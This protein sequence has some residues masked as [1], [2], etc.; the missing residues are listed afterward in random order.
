M[1]RDSKVRRCCP[2]RTTGS[3]SG[4]SRTPAPVAAWRSAFVI[5]RARQ[6]W[7]TPTPRRSTSSRSACEAT[8]AKAAPVA[9]VSIDDRAARPIEVASATFTDFTLALDLATEGAA[10]THMLEVAF[11]NG[12]AEQPLPA[13]HRPRQGLVPRGRSAA[14][15]DPGCAR[16]AGRSSGKRRRRP[17]AE[18]GLC[19]RARQ[20]QA[21]SPHR[22][23]RQTRGPPREG[24]GGRDRRAS[25]AAT[26]RTAGQAASPAPARSAAAC[27]RE[28][29]ARSLLNASPEGKP[30]AP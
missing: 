16:T 26:P 12:F 19:Q 8:T 22:P 25:R 9:L 14:G 4:T 7:S 28:D 23:P 13:D 3:R 29:R 11:D 18:Q 24:Q 1:N 5:R 6:R 15:G 27:C 2:C 17:P 21:T 10:G 30:G 20:A